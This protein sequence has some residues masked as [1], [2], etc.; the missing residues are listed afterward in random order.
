MRYSTLLGAAVLTA[1]FMAAGPSSAAA[2]PTTELCKPTRAQYREIHRLGLDAIRLIGAHQKALEMEAHFRRLGDVNQAQQWRAIAEAN[3]SLE[4]ETFIRT[5]EKIDEYYCIEAPPGTEYH[6]ERRWAGWNDTIARFVKTDD[7]KERKVLVFTRSAFRRNIEYAASVKLHEVRHAWQAHNCMSSQPGYW[8]DDSFWGHLAEYDAY[9]QQ[10]LAHDSGAIRVE[11]SFK[12]LIRSRM[13][14]HAGGMSRHFPEYWA[15]FQ[16]DLVRSIPGENLTLLGNVFNPSAEVQEFAVSIEDDLGWEI[17]PSDLTFVTLQP[18]EMQTIE[19]MVH[20]PLDAEAGV[21]EFRLSTLPGLETT[22]SDSAFVVVVPY[23][24]IAGPEG[25]THASRGEEAAVEFH[26]TSPHPGSDPV[27]IIVELSNDEGWPMTNELAVVTISEDEPAT[28]QTILSVPEELPPFT[29]G[30]VT[31]T[32]TPAD[33]PGGM[34]TAD[35]VVIISEF[36]L[37]P[38]VP[39]SPG[40]ITHSGSAVPVTATVMNV[41]DRGTD[42]PFD[43]TFRIEG[44]GEDGPVV[45][46]ERQTVQGIGAQEMIEVEF[47]PAS[48]H[49][50]GIYTATIT[51]PAP[52]GP[53]GAPEDVDPTNDEMVIPF[54]VIP[55]S[56]QWGIH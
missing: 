4:R 36:D 19:Y 11:D 2:Y 15:I 30:L 48:L 54:E 42:E 18:E 21:N 25:F 55:P 16:Q 38:L 45:Y 51:A 44:P 39:L 26:M 33:D 28:V 41:G 32:A 53:P 5:L 35:R 27:E 52:D 8:E 34:V 6:F 43:V 31:L 50:P 24:E 12:R 47:P 17:H 9:R 3:A 46:D 29:I 20:V 49:Q 37:A 14:R 10:E 7:V 1:A 40:A 13:R 23:I 56:D 22:P